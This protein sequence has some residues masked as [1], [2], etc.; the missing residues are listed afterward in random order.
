MKSF[1]DEQLTKLYQY[2]IENAKKLIKEK[3]GSQVPYY[4][5]N[6]SMKDYCWT[7]IHIEGLGIIDMYFTGISSVV[8]VN[9]VFVEEKKVIQFNFRN[10]ERR[11]LEE[12]NDQKIEASKEWFNNL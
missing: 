2:L 3:R 11:L 7:V 9:G 4:P 8:K 10:A 6:P 5:N 1:T 12:L